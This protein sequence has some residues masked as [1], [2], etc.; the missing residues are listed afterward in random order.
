MAGIGITGH[1]RPVEGGTRD[2]GPADA[3]QKRSLS[4]VVRTVSDMALMA[5]S[6]TPKK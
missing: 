1:Y 5:L 6:V 2:I 4:H 3:L